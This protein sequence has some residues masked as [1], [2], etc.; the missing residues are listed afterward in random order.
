MKTC[1]V[2]SSATIKRKQ[3]ILD[4]DIVSRIIT[5]G[6]KEKYDKEKHQN[7]SVRVKIISNMVSE[8][9]KLI[10]RKSRKTFKILRNL[11]FCL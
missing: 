6:Q 7:L 10:F 2:C 9:H 1:G 8:T 5:F 3:I 4:F 11:R